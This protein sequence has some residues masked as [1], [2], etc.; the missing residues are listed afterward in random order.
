M[1]NKIPYHFYVSGAHAP[2]PPIN[3]CT[4]FY[5]PLFVC[6]FF[7]DDKFFLILLFRFF[8]NDTMINPSPGTPFFSLWILSF[9]WC[10]SPFLLNAQQSPASWTPAPFCF[11]VVRPAF[12]FFFSDSPGLLA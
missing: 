12:Q 3:L 8:P 6:W 4:S 10:V 9:F 1:G 11:W 7:P 2:P 5:L